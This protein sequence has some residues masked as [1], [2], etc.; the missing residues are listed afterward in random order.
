ML[1]VPPHGFR[2]KQKRH[3]TTHFAHLILHTSSYL[4]FHSIPSPRI[5]SA[6]PLSPRF[7]LAFLLLL[8]VAR[9][10]G[11]DAR[12]PVL[13]RSPGRRGRSQHLTAG[14]PLPRNPRASRGADARGSR[15]RDSM[16]IRV[17]NCDQEVV[18][19]LFSRPCW[20]S[21]RNMLIGKTPFRRVP[22]PTPMA[23]PPILL[24]V[25]PRCGA[26]GLCQRGAEGEGTAQASAT[27]PAGTTRVS[28]PFGV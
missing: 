22:P 18:R 25:A 26:G 4:P 6:E 13:P 3:L 17:S 24:A 27:L 14:A 23:S 10:F 21:P 8:A 1:H 9:R 5:V 16:K 20:E 19:S 12:G 11:V 15:R 7:S 28:F 2:P